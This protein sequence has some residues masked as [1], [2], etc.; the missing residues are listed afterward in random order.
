MKN[1][2]Y[3]LIVLLMFTQYACKQKVITKDLDITIHVDL[4]MEE[5]VV[6]YKDIFSKIEIIP[7]ET[8]DESV[9]GGTPEY[10]RVRKD[11]SYYIF[12][13]KSNSIV[14]FD[15]TGAFVKNIN[16]K[17]QGPGE[18]AEITDFN[19]NRFTGNLE[20]LSPRGFV[21]I[22]DSTGVN[23]IETIKIGEPA[24]EFA[25]L[26]DDIYVFYSHFRKNSKIFF[27]SKK[28]GQMV[29]ETFPLPDF[30]Y[31]KTMFH[32]T[33]PPFYVYRN[34]LCFYDAAN[35]DVY[36]IDSETMKLKPRYQW[37][38]GKYTFDISLIND[39]DDRD[40]MYY[41][42]FFQ[43]DNRY[44]YCFLYNVE[45][46][47]YF[48]TTFRFRQKFMTVIYNKNTKKHLLFTEFLEGGKCT[49]NLITDEY[50]YVIASIELLPAII[51]NRLLDE[52]NQ[53]KL[54][55]IRPDDNCVI[56][57]YKFK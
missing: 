24:H 41:L 21:Y 28:Q 20:I 2:K 31:K 6:S 17:G 37:D 51:N 29:N 18:Y 4:D 43:Y 57:G 48:I 38:M 44:A 26:T 11:G 36:T 30:V 39:N 22:Y 5:D 50:I 54:E 55:Q 56:I 52:E 34:D 14:V 10:L 46:D 33:Y 8:N 13:H 32:H 9:F 53:K 25:N 16:K 42:D 19:F 27:F 23:Y 40:K 49:P 3:I 12:P 15:K 7:L 1:L 47:N 45:N 35:G